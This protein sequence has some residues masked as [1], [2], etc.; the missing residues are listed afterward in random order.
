[1]TEGVNLKIKNRPSQNKI[2]SLNSFG[3]SHS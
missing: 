2:V 3:E 1:M